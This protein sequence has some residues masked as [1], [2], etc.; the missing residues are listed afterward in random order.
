[1]ISPTNNFFKGLLIILKLQIL[2]N[3]SNSSKYRTFL[4]FF[5]LN[6]NGTLTSKTMSMTNA[7]VAKHNKLASVV[8]GQGYN[9]Y[10]QKYHFGQK[11]EII[12]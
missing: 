5:V 4:L 2:L 8:K 1:M 6:V 7:Q 3:S 10:K 11:M 12:S 9:W